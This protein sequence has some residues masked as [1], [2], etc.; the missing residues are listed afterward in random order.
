[1]RSKTAGRSGSPV[2]L[3]PAHAVL[4]A[5]TISPTEERPVAFTGA[6]PFGF[7]RHRR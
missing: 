3:K 1:M 2:V 6:S 5:L 4:P 7:D